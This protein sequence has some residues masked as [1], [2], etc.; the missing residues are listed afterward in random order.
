M[1]LYPILKVRNGKIIKGGV[2]L[3]QD[4]AEALTK[5]I[6]KQSKKFK[7]I[8]LL[9]GYYEDVEI[10]KKVKENL[11]SKIDVEVSFSNL[12][13]PSVGSVMGS[14]TIMASWTGI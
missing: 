14:K 1:Q 9:I 5:M 6:L 12:I 8:R 7:K 11:K 2:V 3:A 4:V 13:P 10:V